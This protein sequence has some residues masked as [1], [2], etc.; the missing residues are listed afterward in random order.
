MEQYVALLT[1]LQRFADSVSA[2]SC[3][4]EAT[5]D[6]GSDVC[7]NEAAALQLKMVAVAAILVSSAA[8]VAIPLVGHRWRGAVRAGE[9]GWAFVLAK[10]FAAGVVLGT[11]YV[12]MMHDAEEKFLDPCLPDSS[13]WQQFPFAGS[14]A[15]LAS[16]VTLVV[17]FIGTQFYERKQRDKAGAAS[18]TT[19]AQDET[20]SPLLQDGRTTGGQKCE[21]TL[22]HS[23]AHVYEGVVRNGHG[24]ENEEGPSQARQVVVS[25]VRT[26]WLPCPSCQAQA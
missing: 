12:H 22:G 2:V 24:H 23:H 6:G 21:A 19:S 7:R 11:G 10:A 16:L 4:A 13:P 18:A 1:Y 8:G 14:V 26:Q 3:D 20:G 5:G 25:Q 15:M 9:G 17:D